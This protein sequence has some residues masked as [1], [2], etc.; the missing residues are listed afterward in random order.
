MEISFPTVESANLPTFTQAVRIF[1]LKAALGHANIKGSY[2]SDADLITSA[3]SI[4]NYI[5]HG[6]ESSK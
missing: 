5:L 6:K 4:E 1:S 3:D 2:V